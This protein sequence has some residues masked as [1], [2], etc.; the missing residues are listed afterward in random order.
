MSNPETVSDV[1]PSEIS[2]KMCSVTDC[3]R[4][5]FCR[6]WCTMH[7][8]RWMRNGTTDRLPAKKT[9]VADR[10]WAKVQIADLDECWLWTAYV[11]PDGYGTLQADGASVLA[12]RFSWE[13]HNGPIPAGEGP[14]GTCVLHH[15]D[16]P[17]CVNPAHLF[18]G[19]HAD[20]MHDMASKGRNGQLKGSA[21]PCAKLTEVDVL[22]IRKRYAAGGISQWDLADEF[23]LW[24]ST[25][26]SILLGKT[27]RH[28]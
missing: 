14:H 5:R 21:K 26:S 16:T 15:C 27:W 13:L 23:G 4:P 24:Q 3:S 12:H 9:L 10:F 1:N 8:S 17:A 19:S 6:G 7:Y 18:L 25:I 2:S 28:V 20:N 11:T 22:S